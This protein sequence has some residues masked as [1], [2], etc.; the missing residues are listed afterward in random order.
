MNDGFRYPW[1]VKRDIDGFFG[2]AIDNLIQF[3]LIATMCPLIAGIPS[4]FVFTRILPGAA[5]SVVLGNFYYSW[6]ARKLAIKEKRRTVTALPYGINTV[7]LFAYLIF[8][9]GPVYRETGSYEMAWKVGLLACFFSGVIEFGGSFIFDVLRRI[10]PRAALLSTLAGIAITFIS[11]DF[12]FQTFE[13]PLIAMLPL[14]IIFIQYFSK[15]RFPFGLPGGMVA[16][17]A[18]TI[19]AWAF[20]I[21][22]TGAVGTAAG[23]VGF[24]PPRFSGAGLFEVMKS[25]YLLRYFSIIIPMG[26]FNVIG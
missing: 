13:K 14:A 16:L 3:L 7:S 10:T 12:A 1:I 11:M 15:V 20:G 26:L 19:L 8:I 24:N 2:L 9:M 6:Q 23:N 4:S 18:G 22:D 21:M 25:P 5:L 17:A